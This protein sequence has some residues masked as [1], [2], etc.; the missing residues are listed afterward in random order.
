MFDT[1]RVER[2][3]FAARRSV[4]MAR[5]GMVA[6]SQPRLLCSHSPKWQ[7]Q[8]EKRSES[9]LGPTGSGRRHQPGP[10]HLSAAAPLDAGGDAY[11][12]LAAPQ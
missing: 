6:S 12:G 4:V 9:W 1:N 10:E 8:P 3:G 5:D 2:A 7:Y 11:Q